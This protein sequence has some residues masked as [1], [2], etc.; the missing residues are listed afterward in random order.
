MTATPN[1]SPRR[2]RIKELPFNRMIPNILTLLALSAGMTAMRF[3]IQERWEDAVLAITVA[4]ILDALDGRVARVLKGASKFGAE[5]DSLA[6]FI[7][8]GVSPAM[9]MYLWTMNDAGRVGWILVLVFAICCV[10]RLAR[11]NTNLDLPEMPTWAYN[12]FN[13]IPAPAGAG[14]VLFPMILSFQFGDYIFRNP[15]FAGPLMLVV[16]GLLVSRIPT[17]AFKKFKVP[18]PW[19]LPTM[20]FV[21]LLAAFAISVPWFTLSMVMA[22]YLISIP[23]SVRS[24]KRL[25]RE[26]EVNDMD[27]GMGN[28]TNDTPR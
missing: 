4:A 6:D 1:P 21:G 27:A 28:G 12:Y 24:Y 19:V 14:L 13:G 26:E 15:W 3:A 17:Y 23:F 5:L 2:K 18:H 8:F 9:M 16:G 20:L 10:L 22:V 25:Q 11:F 7:N